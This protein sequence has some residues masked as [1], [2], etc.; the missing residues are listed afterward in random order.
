MFSILK[1]LPPKLIDRVL[2]GVSLEEQ[3]GLSNEANLIVPWPLP[4]VIG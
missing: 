4:G 3:A 2:K 1:L